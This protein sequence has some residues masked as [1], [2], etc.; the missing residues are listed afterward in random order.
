[1]GGGGWHVH[2]QC[3]T[4]FIDAWTRVLGYQHSSICELMCHLRAMT[5]A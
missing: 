3:I 5:L 4:P 1:V 2:A